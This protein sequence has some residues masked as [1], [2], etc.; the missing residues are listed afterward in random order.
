V[1]IRPKSSKDVVSLIAQ[2]LRSKRDGAEPDHIIW[3]RFTTAEEKLR[4]LL[5]S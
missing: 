1:E 4:K 3:C 5:E 2:V